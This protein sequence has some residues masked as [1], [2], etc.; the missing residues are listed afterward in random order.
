MDR[1]GPDIWAYG[2]MAV[3]LLLAACTDVRTGRIYN[4]ITYPA[5][6]VALVGHG[7]TGGLWGIP[8]MPATAEAPAQPGVMG[9]A[10]ALAGFAV[11]FLPLLVAW[12]AGGI[13]GGD[14]KIMGVVGALGGWRFAL[15][16]ML[17]GFVVAA[18][19]ALVVLLLRR[20]L[21]DT[22]GRIGRFLWLLLMRASPGDPAAADSPTIPF[23]LAL[24]IGALA[25][26]VLVC[27]VGPG[28]TM[29]LLGI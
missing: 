5:L 18:G 27:I 26:L 4:W 3:T 13:G 29:L 10:G 23:G 20:R 25:A 15:S 16:A 7:L 1:L 24:C 11:G 2:V 12:L 9:L 21:R 22:L 28:E 6:V 14:A 17:Y 19:M 8:A